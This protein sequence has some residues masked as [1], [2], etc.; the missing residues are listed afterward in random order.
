MLEQI[1]RLLLRAGMEPTPPG[2]WPIARGDDRVLS[3][4]QARLL[5]Q[6]RQNKW[7]THWHV[8]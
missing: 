7:I 5:N 4:R 1:T 2:G 3:A 6:A 8:V